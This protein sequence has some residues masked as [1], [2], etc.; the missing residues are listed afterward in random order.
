MTSPTTTVFYVTGYTGPTM[1]RAD[2]AIGGRF[3]PPPVE[4]HDEGGGHRVDL[5]KFFEL[6]HADAFL[7]E[8]GGSQIRG[9]SKLRVEERTEP[10]ASQH[11]EH[12]PLFADRG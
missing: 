6:A 9:Y 12:L 10:V 1:T 8:K 3:A 5:A 7:E 4:G 11:T 2:A